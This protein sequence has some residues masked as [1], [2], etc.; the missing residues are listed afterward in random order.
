MTTQATL[1]EIDESWEGSQ[2][3]YE[4]RGWSDGLPI[5]PA[6]PE[7]VAA[8]LRY[9]DRDPDSVV[10]QIAPRNGLATVHA[11]AVNCIMAGCRPEYLPVVIA[12]TEAVADPVLNLNA[13]NS[14]TH[15][16]GLFVL[17]NGPIGRELDINSKNNCFGPCW[18]ANAT[19]GR[20]L[21]LIM[22]TV[23]GSTPVGGEGDISTQGSP[24][25]YTFCAAENEE[26]SPWEP[27]HVENG[28]DISSSTVTVVAAEGP[29]NIIGT[30]F[31]GEGVLTMVAGAMSGSGSSNMS[32]C[33]G[34]PVIVLSP[35]HAAQVAKDGYSKADVK[36]FV[37]EHARFPLARGYPEMQERRRDE[38]SDLRISE[39]PERID[40]IVAG[41]EG[42]H[43][44][45]IPTFGTPD[46]TNTVI[47][48]ITRADGTP[49]GS[50]RDF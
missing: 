39:A 13:V 8:M 19:I 14:T 11:V 2:D 50:V 21:R 46:L 36:R 33:A 15:P 1:L 29:Q 26:A 9:T 27:F 48:P 45:W 38:G 49:L 37:W 34:E 24:V 7:R 12:A 16:C 20:A 22:L 41:G 44:S 17:V 30:S 25:K 28:Y 4:Q 3:L 23:G 10:G 6:T 47:R 32:Q 43:S 35:P 5:V 31:S 40:V 42:T 18:R